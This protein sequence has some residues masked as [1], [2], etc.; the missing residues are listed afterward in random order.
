M[1]PPFYD[2]EIL[3]ERGID[4]FIYI[5]ISL[6]KTRKNQSIVPVYN[7][8]LGYYGIIIGYHDLGLWLM[9]YIYISVN[10][11]IWGV[12]WPGFSNMS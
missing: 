2:P 7:D 1:L 8:I 11:M 5:Y 6:K 9:G 12:N 4:I 10:N 3:S